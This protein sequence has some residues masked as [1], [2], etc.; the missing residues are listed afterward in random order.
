MTVQ[1]GSERSQRQND[2]L[3][4]ALLSARL[5]R[6]RQGEEQRHTDSLRRRQVG[7]GQRG[8][9][10][11]AIRTQANQVNVRARRENAPVHAL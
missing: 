8:D 1:C 6:Q 7:S 4:L 3:A 5:V 10:T 9:E 2:G 11:R